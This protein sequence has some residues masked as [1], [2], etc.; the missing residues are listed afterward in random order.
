[1]LHS[2]AVESND[3][4]PGFEGCPESNLKKELLHIPQIK[5]KCPSKVGLCQIVSVHAIRILN[6]LQKSA[7]YAH[8]V[9]LVLN[10]H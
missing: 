3:L 9:I 8:V 2:N 5:W 4:P 7:C 10:L 1:M 6:V